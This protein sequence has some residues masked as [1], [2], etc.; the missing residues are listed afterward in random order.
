MTNLASQLRAA[1]TAS[2]RSQRELGK[3]SGVRQQNIS[4]F[5]AGKSLS[6]ANLEALAAALGFEARLVKVKKAS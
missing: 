3:A 6:V 4:V 5:M 2:G 1:I